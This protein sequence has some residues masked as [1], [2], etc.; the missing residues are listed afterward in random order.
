MLSHVSSGYALLLELAY[1][2]AIFSR[3]AR[4]II[5]WG[6]IAMQTGIAL[7]M[8]PN[9]WQL[10][11]CQLLWFPL[12]KFYYAVVKRPSPPKAGIFADGGIREFTDGSRLLR[13]VQ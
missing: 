11:I 5:P 1:P 10:I 3:R 6:G 13:S 8:G 9:F 12:D 2:L 7:L 4:R